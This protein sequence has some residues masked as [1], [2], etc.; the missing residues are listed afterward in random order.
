MPQS[1]ESYQPPEVPF[2]SRPLLIGSLLSAG[3][4]EAGA[5]TTLQESPYS[6]VGNHL[7]RL[8][9]KE[10]RKEYYARLEE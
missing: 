5:A 2:G 9:G 6:W 4:R 7:K 10:A 3:P 8:E 1:V